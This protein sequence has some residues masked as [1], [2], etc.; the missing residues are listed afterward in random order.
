MFIIPNGGK[1]GC[2][3]DGNIWIFFFSNYEILTSTSVIWKRPH[4]IPCGQSWYLWRTKIQLFF[5]NFLWDSDVYIFFFQNNRSLNIFSKAICIVTVQFYKALEY[6]INNS[7]GNFQT[8]TAQE[9]M[10]SFTDTCTD[11]ITPFLLL[12]ENIT[13]L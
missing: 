6:R 9:Q 2:T 3:E 8:L 13:I 12:K 11:N 7:I 5:F 10:S 1:L 4:V